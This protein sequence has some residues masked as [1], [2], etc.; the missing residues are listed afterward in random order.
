MDDIIDR[1]SDEF[2]ELIGSI[3]TAIAKIEQVSAH[4]KPPICNERYLTG[5]E[6]CRIFHISKRTLQ[7][8]R[9]T[10]V[11]PF[12]QIGHKCYYKR[13]DVELLL[14]TKSEKSKTDKPKNNK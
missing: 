2:R 14:Q 4:L 12:A 11:L 7:H 10:G 3:E 5:E 1:G 13:E 8:Y 9:D 6:I